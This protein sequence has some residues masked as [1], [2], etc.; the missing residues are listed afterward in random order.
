M[1]GSSPSG[2]TGYIW[3]MMMH[4]GYRDYGMHQRATVHRAMESGAYGVC[5]CLIFTSEIPYLRCCI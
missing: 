5:V 2:F 3:N 4:E 1:G